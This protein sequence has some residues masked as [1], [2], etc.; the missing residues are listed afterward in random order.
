[1]IGLMVGLVLL[2]L[3]S[4]GMLFDTTTTKTKTIMIV[5]QHTPV[6]CLSALTQANSDL[7]LYQHN[8]VELQK[9]LD[10]ALAGQSHRAESLA[11]HTAALD[12]RR[13]QIDAGVC[14][15]AH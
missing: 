10:V 1:M 14:R 13:F 3:V 9:A 12:A 15:L 8:Q 7:R 4:F 6:S 11:A 5:K 2:A